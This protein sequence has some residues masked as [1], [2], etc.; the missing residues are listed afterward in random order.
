MDIDS[1]TESEIS[2]SG[3]NHCHA[4]DNAYTHQLGDLATGT[5]QS[6]AHVQ[7]GFEGGCLEAIQFLTELDMEVPNWVCFSFF[8]TSLSS[9]THLYTGVGRHLA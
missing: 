6:T 3:E 8:L 1:E 4:V 7:R 5:V 9:K 2:C